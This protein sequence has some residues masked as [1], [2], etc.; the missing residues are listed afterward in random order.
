MAHTHSLQIIIDDVSHR[1]VD[2]DQ[3]AAALLRLA[4]RDPKFYDL[5]HIGKRGVEEHVRDG[6]IVNLK[7]GDRFSTRQKIRFSID[8]ESFSTYDNDQEA[9]AL[10]RL[11][12]VNP[13]EYDLARI[14][15]TGGPETFQDSALVTLQD[16]DEFVTAKCIGGVA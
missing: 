12:G 5:F 14:N 2:D 4:G 6:Q 16:G 7:D 8:G 3:Q 13:G 1:T 15:G 10:L 9:A 11:A